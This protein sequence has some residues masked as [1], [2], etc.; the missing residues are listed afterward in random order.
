MDGNRLKFYLDENIEIAIAKQLMNRHIEVFTVRDLG[1]LGRDDIFHLNNAT[2]MGCVLCTYDSD[3]L[4]LASQGIEH[5]G[6]V[7]GVWDKHTI[8]DW[9]KMLVF[10]YEILN[11]DDMRNR[12]EYLSSLIG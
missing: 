11:A 9:V 5:A 3:Y 8:G 4:E 1:L 2:R 10:I 12:V 7:F 6:I